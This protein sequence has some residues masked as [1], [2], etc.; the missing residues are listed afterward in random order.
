MPG[1][2]NKPATLHDVA[3][4]AGVSYQTVSRVV[5]HHPN[6]ARETR[7]RVLAA[8]DQAT[9][10]PNRAARC[11]ITG[12][13]QT[14][15]VIIFNQVF[16]KPVWAF[17]RVAREY[18]Y[19]L[20]I[21]M[22]NDP[23]AEDELFQL[24]GESTSRM[25]D[26]FLFFE[27]PYEL[28]DERIDRFCHGTPFVQIGA[29]PAPK[30]P[31]LVFDQEC[32]IEQVLDHL[33]G[34]GHRKIAE[35]YNLEVYDGRKRHETYLEGMK[36]RGLAPGPGEACNF[37]VP[38][39]YAAAV[40]LLERGEAFT[41]ILWGN[42]DVALG[43]LRA[44]HER[45]KHVP[46]DVSVTG[47]DDNVDVSYYEPPLT[48]V[49]QDYEAQSRQGIQYLVSLIQHPETPREQR[50]IYPQLIVRQSTALVAGEAPLLPALGRPQDKE[51]R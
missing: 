45:G 38:G 24:L 47:F 36:K 51:P 26:G 46:E 12:R 11:L 40:R 2:P 49:R 5:N 14:L 23:A 19:H 27:P 10:I 17:V 37:S 9:Y 8:I 33:C 42:D 41:A 3:R 48:T 31:A 28:D 30:M 21:S 25:V 34:L 29:C 13:S 20:G 1:G 16:Y 7:Q 50:K 35:I 43:A 18:G 39:G 6:V 15:Q 22:L 32:G 4:L 44:L